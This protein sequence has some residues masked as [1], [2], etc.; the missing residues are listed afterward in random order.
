[1]KNE[2]TAILQGHRDRE[3]E[4]RYVCQ[5]HWVIDM[6]AGPV[7]KGRCQ[8]CGMHREFPNYL[9]DCLAGND[10]ETYER[11]LARQGQQGRRR[12]RTKRGS[13]FAAGED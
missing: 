8:T 9:S 3:A 1:M 12:A 7:S 11:W 2:E 6:A 13:I 4:N 10:K 5:H